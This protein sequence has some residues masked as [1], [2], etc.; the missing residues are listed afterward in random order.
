MWKTCEVK[1]TEDNKTLFIGTHVLMGKLEHVFPMPVHQFLH[2]WGRL[3]AGELI[4]NAFDNLD[5][6]ER[7]FLISGLTP[8]KWDEV[9]GR[10]VEEPEEEDLSGVVSVGSEE[11]SKIEEPPDVCP[12]DLII[13]AEDPSNEQKFIDGKNLGDII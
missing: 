6:N 13:D 3:V 8:E 7:E 12:D 4:Q 2:R 11:I 9:F 5:A 1:P 10:L